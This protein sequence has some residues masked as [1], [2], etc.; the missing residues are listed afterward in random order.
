[1]SE[2]VLGLLWNILCET[3]RVLHRLQYI[4][5]GQVM[6]TSSSPMVVFLFSLIFDHLSVQFGSVCL[7]CSSCRCRLCYRR[8]YNLCAIRF[9]DMIQQ[10]AR[11]L[12]N[13]FK[14][15]LSGFSSTEQPLFRSYSLTGCR[16][17]KHNLLHEPVANMLHSQRYCEKLTQN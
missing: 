7:I 6:V 15:A 11:F 3:F 4:W 9:L 17:S 1:M 10:T 8:S 12:V 14:S 5:C 16:I 13:N 2:F